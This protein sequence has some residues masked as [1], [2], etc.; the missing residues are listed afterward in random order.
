MVNK[1]NTLDVTAKLRTK[2]S[3]V[4]IVP[5]APITIK[6]FKGLGADAP[7]PFFFSFTV[8]PKR[9]VPITWVAVYCG[10]TFCHLCLGSLTEGYSD[11]ALCLSTVV[12][13]LIV[14]R[15][16]ERPGFAPSAITV[17][18]SNARPLQTLRRWFGVNLRGDGSVTP[19]AAADRTHAWSSERSTPHNLT[20]E[21]DKAR[22]VRATQ[23]LK[24]FVLQG[25]NDRQQG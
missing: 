25:L 13:D 3:W 2:G 23:G 19:S 10:G 6:K 16:A 5:G 8:V 22:A 17:A 20:S 4:R 14:V 7:R 9:S 12:T 15:A 18:S 24:Y 1:N 11:V 21:L